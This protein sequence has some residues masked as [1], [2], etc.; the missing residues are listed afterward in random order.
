MND[1]PLASF[2]SS[3]SAQGIRVTLRDYQRIALVLRVIQGAPTLIRLRNTLVALLSSDEEQERTIF[4]QFEV[5][6]DLNLNAE[7]RFSNI[8]LSRALAELATLAQTQKKPRR[9]PIWLNPKRYDD[10]K[11]A[12]VLNRARW[13][14]SSPLLRRCIAAS[15]ILGMT[16]SLAVISWRFKLFSKGVNVNATQPI[17]PTPPP[18]PGGLLF[19]VVVMLA[20]TGI[21][22]FLAKLA[23]N[24]NPRWNPDGPRHFPFGLIGGKPMPRL[25]PSSVDRLAD[26]LGYFRSEEDGNALDLA[27]TIDRTIKNGGIPTL[28]FQR[29]NNARAVIVLADALSESLLW[30]QAPEELVRGLRSRGTPVVFGR[31]AGSP[32]DFR[33]D[34]MVYHL[35]DL[36]RD[37]SNYLI[38]IFSDGAGLKR[39]NN[40]ALE[41]LARWPMIAWMELRERRFWDERTARLAHHK[42]PIH[43]AT[44]EGIEA[45]SKTLGEDGISRQRFDDDPQ[46]WRGAPPQVGADLSWTIEY[47]LGD[48]IRWAQ[49]C[50]V[51]QPVSL[52]LADSLRRE[53]HPHLPP[54]RIDRLFTMPGANYGVGGL[55]FPQPVLRQLLLGFNTRHSKFEQKQIHAFILRKVAERKP[56]QP[57]SLA[58]L[59]WESTMQLVRLGIEPD[60]ASKQ[61]EKLSHSPLEV[62]IGRELETRRSISEDYSDNKEPSGAWGFTSGV[63]YWESKRRVPG[64]IPAKAKIK[65]K[66][67]Y[68]AEAVA[69]KISGHVSVAVRVDGS[70]NVRSAQG[71]GPMLLRSAATEAALQWKFYPATSLG[72]RVEY[73]ETIIFRFRRPLF[74]G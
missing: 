34:E 69:L 8:D 43:S 29:Q 61:L 51:L 33:T 72:H 38:L 37:R 54:Q 56:D 60:K 67:H 6:F 25:D 48:S 32:M 40:L 19:A 63:D 26:S 44:S 64:I 28:I 15:L 9:K 17:D 7:S 65:V 1:F 74:F 24:R 41:F 12:Q 14:W 36:E 46:A 73:Y 3:L 70:G 5:F 52:G 4:R 30:N 21:I 13:L 55:R 59:I 35:E 10:L 22:L 58:Y 68:P 45:L 47:L 18:D 39:E 31:F 20:I 49:A 62:F 16:G 42:I 11:E 53:F 66:A 2:L 23:L 50:A 71:F 27:A 57:E